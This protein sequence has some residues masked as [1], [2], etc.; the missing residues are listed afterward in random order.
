MFAA[1]HKIR[2][3]IS[4]QESGQEKWL[5]SQNVDKGLQGMPSRAQ[6]HSPLVAN[7]GS[8]KMHTTVFDA[9]IYIYI[10]ICIIGPL[11]HKIN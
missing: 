8:V 3:L 7:E 1:L 6:R 4:C 9:Y 5:S 10:Y 2:R 11:V